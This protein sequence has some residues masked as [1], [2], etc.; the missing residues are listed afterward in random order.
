MKKTIL[1]VATA[2][3]VASCSSHGEKNTV[4]PDLQTSEQ[5]VSEQVVTISDTQTK[6]NKTTEIVSEPDFKKGKTLVEKS[7]CLTCHRETEKMIGPTY[8]EIASRYAGKAGVE[9]TLVQK[10]IQGGSGNWGSIPMSP[11]QNISIE[12]V[13]LM[14]KYILAVNKK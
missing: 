4:T 5:N 11:H 12:D 2:V 3:V 7:D 1:S 9:E 13:N 14:L 10:I 8:A 6:E